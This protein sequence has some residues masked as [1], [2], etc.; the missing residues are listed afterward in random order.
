LPVP[1]A[2]TSCVLF[3]PP[4]ELPG[5]GP[6]RF[7][8]IFARSETLRRLDGPCS[9]ERSPPLE[10]GRIELDEGIAQNRTESRCLQVRRK[11]A[12]QACLVAY[13]Q[14]VVGLL[15]RTDER[16]EFAPRHRIVI[17]AKLR[18]Y[19]P[20][21]SVTTTGN[22]IDADVIASQTE[23]PQDS[24]RRL[25][26]GPSFLEIQFGSESQVDVDKVLERSTP[27]LFVG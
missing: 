21:R 19:S 20:Q 4:P 9:F 13:Q 8:L 17:G 10:E 24:S 12:R 7:A 23:L 6:D 1:Q 15:T 5:N 27:T 14:A 3:A 26:D 22:E 11:V 2:A 16:T 18:L 25:F